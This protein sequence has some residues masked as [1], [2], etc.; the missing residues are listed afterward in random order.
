MSSE[1]ID[2]F[3]GTTLNFLAPDRELEHN[4]AILALLFANLG[5]G[6]LVDGLAPRALHLLWAGDELEHA[7]AVVADQ[8]RAGHWGDACGD[9]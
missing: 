4:S 9:R 1:L 7:A 6:H 5:R 2:V 3:A 8:M